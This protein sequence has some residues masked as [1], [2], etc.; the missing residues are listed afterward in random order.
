MTKVAKLV[1]ASLG[2]EYQVERRCKANF[3]AVLFANVP[4]HFYEVCCDF[5]RCVWLMLFEQIL[6]SF[7]QSHFASFEVEEAEC[8]YL[9]LEG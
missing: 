5:L 1:A 4:E 8:N 7:F 3:S 9:L 6:Y 2:S